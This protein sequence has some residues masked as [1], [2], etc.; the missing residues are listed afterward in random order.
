MAT[1]LVGPSGLDVAEQTLERLIVRR[2]DL[3]RR[4][5]GTKAEASAKTNAGVRIRSRA[6][7]GIRV[8]IGS[9][10]RV[11]ALPPRHRQP[12]HDYHQHDLDDQA[13]DRGQAAKAAEQATAEQHAEQ[14]RAEEPG[15][16]AAQEATAAA[17]QAAARRRGCGRIHACT[18]LGVGAI[19]LRRRTRRGRGRRR[20]RIGPRAARTGRHAAADARV[21]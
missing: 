18:G 14:A 11:A 15:R 10:R 3:E 16:K 17:E 13:Q 7:T 6:G 4:V 20:G 9:L 5:V 12:H 8:G 1:S 21:G 19:E 2:L